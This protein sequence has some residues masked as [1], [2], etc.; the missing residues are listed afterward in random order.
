MLTIHDDRHKR[1]VS[2]LTELRIAIPL[3]QSDLAK[4]LGIGQSDVSKVEQ[5][6][7]RL[8]IVELSDWV[9]ALGHDLL[10]FLYEVGILAPIPAPAPAAPAV[11]HESEF[12]PDPSCKLPLKVSQSKVEVR[13]LVETRWELRS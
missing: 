6:Q 1:I 9:T 8:D 11:N 3:H 12:I 10:P 4:E 7:R 2:R 13:Q 5:G